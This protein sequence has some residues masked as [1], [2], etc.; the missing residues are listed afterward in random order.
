MGYV[1]CEMKIEYSASFS[2]VKSLEV[3][4]NPNSM[5]TF[6]FFDTEL[7]KQFVIGYMC[8]KTVHSVKFIILSTTGIRALGNWRASVKK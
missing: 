2:W 6:K 7:V 4:I 1:G 5:L 8:V 3:F